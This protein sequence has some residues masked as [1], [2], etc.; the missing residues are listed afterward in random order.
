MTLD[1]VTPD[2]VESVGQ[3][4]A[5]LWLVLRLLPRALGLGERL[6]SELAAWRSELSGA[7]VSVTVEPAHA[8]PVAADVLPYR[9]PP[10]GRT[11]TDSGSVDGYCP[12]TDPPAGIVRRPRRT[13][14]WALPFVRSG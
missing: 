3:T 13:P 1:T 8:E 14:A 2:A 4:G 9:E 12:P 6:V 11:L 10:A 5:A 7:R